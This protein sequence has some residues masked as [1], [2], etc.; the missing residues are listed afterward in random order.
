MRRGSCVAD[1]ASRVMRRMIAKWLFAPE[2]E[3][4]LSDFVY[5][6]TVLV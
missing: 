5:T 3:Y 1:H 4:E 2:I 6:Q